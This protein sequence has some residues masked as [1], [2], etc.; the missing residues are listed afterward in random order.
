MSGQ[1]YLSLE[2]AALSASLFSLSKRGAAGIL[3]LCLSALSLYRGFSSS[4]PALHKAL[5]YTH[6]EKGISWSK[7]EQGQR[8]AGQLPLPFSP[9][10]GLDQ[11]L[12]CVGARRLFQG[13]SKKQI[14]YSSTHPT[15]T[16][17]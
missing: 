15:T 8:Q 3:A 16:G 11:V 12:C 13:D 17:P 2:D 4:R 7:S 6:S 10:D 14:D 5:P 9:K 1:E